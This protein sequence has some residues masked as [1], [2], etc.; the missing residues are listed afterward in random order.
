M[1]DHVVH[2]KGKQMKVLFLLSVSL[3]IGCDRDEQRVTWGM[4]PPYTW[5]HPSADLQESFYYV[6]QNQRPCG[7]LYKNYDGLWVSFGYGFSTQSFDEEVSA[8]VILDNCKN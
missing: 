7:T 1:N 2:R 8:R 6:D 5:V 4:K 3:L